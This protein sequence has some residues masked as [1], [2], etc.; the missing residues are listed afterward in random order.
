MSFRVNWSEVQ[1]SSFFGNGPVKLA[2]RDKHPPQVVVSVGIIALQRNY[3]FK[4]LPGPFKVSLVREQ[5]TQ[6]IAGLC[7]ITL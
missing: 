1:S 3:F 6:V 7:K 2:F 5:D 4:L